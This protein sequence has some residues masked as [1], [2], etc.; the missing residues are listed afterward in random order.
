MEVISNIIRLKGEN[1]SLQSD[2]DKNELSLQLS[3]DEY[4]KFRKSYLE[5]FNIFAEKSIKHSPDTFAPTLDLVNYDWDYFS[6]GQL[7]FLK[8][9]ARLFGV[10]AYRGI[11]GRRFSEWR[12]LSK[13]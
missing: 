8:L 3:S 10:S 12:K 1:Q 11:H 5:Y 4:E 9:F 6:S 7:A 2:F 13:L